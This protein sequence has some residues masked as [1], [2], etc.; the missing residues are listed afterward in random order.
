M[1]PSKRLFISGCIAFPLP[2]PISRDLANVARSKKSRHE[3]CSICI[4]T[5]PDGIRLMIISRPILI[6]LI[7][8]PFKS[9][10]SVFPVATATR[11]R[12]GPSN[13]LLRTFQHF[14]ASEIRQI[15][16]TYPGASLGGGKGRSR[17]E[18][19]KGGNSLH[20]YWCIISTSKATSRR[21]ESSGSGGARRPSAAAGNATQRKRKQLIVDPDFTSRSRK[22]RW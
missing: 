11:G 1:H 2:F 7:P 17:S 16:T 4:E 18:E 15:S 12:S 3:M 20:L 5:S 10:P 22:I 6:S 14:R 19:G 21:K 13:E 9:G 8:K